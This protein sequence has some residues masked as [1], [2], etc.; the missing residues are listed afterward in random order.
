MAMLNPPE[1]LPHLARAIADYLLQHGSQTQEELARVFAPGGLSPTKISNTLQVGLAT[2]LFSK[3][4]A[5][6]VEAPP[7]LRGFQ[8]ASP[9]SP[10][11][12][13][14]AVRDR[15]LDPT[16]DGDPWKTS[17]GDRT[18]GG[19]DIARALSWFLAQD[20]AGCPLTWRRTCGDVQSLQASQGVPQEDRIVNDTRWLAFTRWAPFLGLARW[21]DTSSGSG[22]LPIPVVA[23]SEVA[24]E[25]TQGIAHPIDDLLQHLARRLPVLEGGAYRDTLNTLM[26]EPADPAT[27]AGQ[28]CSAI[29]QSLL[30]LEA[31]GHLRLELKA[32]VERVQLQDEDRTRDVS[33]VVLQRRE[34]S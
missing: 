14:V 3:D 5:G 2:G 6:H 33:H 15:I 12:F 17:A 34:T 26:E 1:S 7:Y 22:L 31:E 10:E 13:R 32:D 8:E 11:E 21:A 16:R 28:V 19:R 30:I 29:A 9:L 24:E 27:R 4:T 20:A 18:S 23:I 25:M